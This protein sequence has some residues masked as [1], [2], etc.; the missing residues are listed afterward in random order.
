M[1]FSPSQFIYTIFIFFTVPVISQTYT[2][3]TPFDPSHIPPAGDYSKTSSWAALPFIKDEADF[4][5]AGLHDSQDSSDVDVFFIHPTTYW[6]K[7]SDGFIWNAD[8]NNPHLKNLVDSR[9]IHYQAS[10]FNGSCKIYAPRY[11]QAH[12]YAFLTEDTASRQKALAL[13]YEDIRA[14][15]RYYLENY[16]HGRPIVIA[17]HS[18]GT[19]HAIRLLR[20]FF[21]NQPL[22]KQLVVAY[23]PGNPVNEQ[24]LPGLTA[25]KDSTQINCFNCWNSFRKNYIP[26]F[27]HKGLDHS[28]CT[29]P[30][31][32]S[33]DENYYPSKCNKGAFVPPFKKI[34][35]GVCDAQ[36]YKGLLWITRPHFRGSRLY[37]SSIY[38]TGD[39]NLFYMDVRENVAL[40]IKQYQNNSSP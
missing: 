38:H 21:L 9:P 2:I 32:W 28:I 40:R 24:M 19:I 10:V 16:N 3:K 26:Y 31:S 36:A 30:L 29:N 22:Q 34:S 35:P 20:E 33:L 15:F 23:L 13:A 17:S 14:A 27:Y 6:Q 11:R 5:P 4:T 39:Y 1:R 37:R 8:I 18:Q 7:P 12:Y 25:C